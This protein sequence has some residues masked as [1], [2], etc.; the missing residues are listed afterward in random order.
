MGYYRI[1]Y[2]LQVHTDVTQMEKTG[3]GI[4]ATSTV[5]LTPVMLGNLQYLPKLFHTLNIICPLP[6]H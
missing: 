1:G 5:D 6:N 2:H 3:I 4:S